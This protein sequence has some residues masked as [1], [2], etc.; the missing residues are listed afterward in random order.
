VLEGA[1]RSRWKS[2]PLAVGS[3]YRYSLVERQPFNGTVVQP[4]TY[5][6]TVRLGL[7]Q[8]GRTIRRL[9]GALVRLRHNGVAGVAELVYM[10]KGILPLV[11]HVL[12]SCSQSKINCNL[13]LDRN[14][15][16]HIIYRISTGHVV[17]AHGHRSWPQSCLVEVG[18]RHQAPF[19]T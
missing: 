10:R 11:R 4:F 12:V 6:L 8:S 3:A 13:S 14:I 19:L 15:S 2:P 17:R 16:S 18:D 9:Q 7:S 1:Q 5:T